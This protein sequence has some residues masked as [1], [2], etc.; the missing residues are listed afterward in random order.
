MFAGQEA[1]GRRKRTVA[2]DDERG[3]GLRIFAS[4]K[5]ARGAN[6]AYLSTPHRGQILAKAKARMSKAC[7]EGKHFSKCWA[8]K[9]TCECHKSGH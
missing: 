8:G 4:T 5:M 6:S 7:T 1:H 2:Q 9:C 3:D